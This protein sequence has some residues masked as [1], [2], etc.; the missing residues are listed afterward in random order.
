MMLLEEVAVYLFGR[1]YEV[2]SELAKKYIGNQLVLLYYIE[3]MQLFLT[4]KLRGLS[5][6]R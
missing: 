4:I 2:Y 1:M 3:V 5:S 6:K